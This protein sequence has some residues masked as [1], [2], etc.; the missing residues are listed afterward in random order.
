M[1]FYFNGFTENEGLK[2]NINTDSTACFFQKFDS[3]KP[4][5]KRTDGKYSG[6]E[7]GDGQMENSMECN[8]LQPGW[9]DSMGKGSNKA[10]G[11]LEFW[12]EEEKGNWMIRGKVT[13]QSQYVPGW[14][15]A[16][17]KNAQCISRTDET[18]VLE[19]HFVY[20]FNYGPL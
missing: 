19:E 10:G 2:I 4:S 8:A 5:V 3:R 18:L 16:N 20:Y 15:Q 11:Y 7:E 13:Y 12:L 6:A 14:Y 17:I 9:V 1:H